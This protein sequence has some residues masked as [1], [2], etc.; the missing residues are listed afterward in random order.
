MSRL[1]T[2]LMVRR[3][4]VLGVALVVAVLLALAAL[5]LQAGDAHAQTSYYG[6]NYIHGTWW[7]L[8]SYGH[9]WYPDPSWSDNYGHYQY[10]LASNECRN[11]GGYLGYTWW[12]GR[13]MVC[14]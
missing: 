2:I 12:S 5:L 11:A 4:A 14:Q 10:W 9:F 6:W 3:T 1:M 8:T 13:W 7:Y